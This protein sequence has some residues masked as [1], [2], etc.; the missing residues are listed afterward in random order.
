MDLN[1]RLPLSVLWFT[2][3]RRICDRNGNFLRFWSSERSQGKHE[4]SQS[5]SDY[6]GIHLHL[7]CTCKLLNNWTLAE[8]NG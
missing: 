5:S 2:L 4:T 3:A 1:I 8:I 7:L 6:Y